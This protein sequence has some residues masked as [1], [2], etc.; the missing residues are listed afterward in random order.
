MTTTKNCFF[1]LILGF[2]TTFLACDY[3]GIQVE[4]TQTQE[5]PPN[6]ACETWQPVQTNGTFNGKQVCQDGVPVAPGTQLS[7]PCD[8][9]DST[10]TGY[11]SNVN[12]TWFCFCVIQ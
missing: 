10:P 9:P 1:A 8:C 7:G 6:P 12:G 2:A 4:E 11:Y 3:E 5:I